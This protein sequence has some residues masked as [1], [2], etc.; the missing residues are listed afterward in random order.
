MPGDRVI[1]SQ[2]RGFYLAWQFMVLILLVRIGF[3]GAHNALVLC[4]I[5]SAQDTKIDQCFSS[6]RAISGGE[7]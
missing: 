7:C 6:L 3:L 2:L 4:S 1:T 5:A